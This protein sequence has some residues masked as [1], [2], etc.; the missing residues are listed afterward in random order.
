MTM[1]FVRTIIT[2]VVAL[3]VVMLPVARLG[4]SV[5]K[6]T[7]MATPADATPS[8][9]TSSADMSAM[10]DCCPDPAKPCDQ[11]DNRCQS[12][13]SC[14]QHTF[15]IAGVSASNLTYPLVAESPLAALVYDGAPLH[16]GSPP[17]RP[18]RS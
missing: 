18:P 11:G 5:V 13:A 4:A 12:M 10:D 17:F 6:S 15:S 16:A 1:R 14:I 3:S 2:L 7:E 9:E 8:A